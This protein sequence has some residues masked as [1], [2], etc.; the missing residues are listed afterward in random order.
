MVQFLTDHWA[1]LLPLITALAMLAKSEAMALDASTRANGL[2][3]AYRQSK[4]ALAVKL[5]PE[6]DSKN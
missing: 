2:I 6:A 3:D 1:E 4:A 5:V